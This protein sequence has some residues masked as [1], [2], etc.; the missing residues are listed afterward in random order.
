M[1]VAVLDRHAHGS[2]PSRITR[3]PITVDVRE[4][5]SG[6]GAALARTAEPVTMGLPFPRGLCT[7]PRVISVVSGGPERAA[8]HIDE[9]SAVQVRVLD[10]WPDGSIR[11]AL[12]DFQ[13]D[14]TGR[15]PNRYDV[16]IHDTPSEPVKGPRIAI[17]RQDQGLT[18]DTGAARFVLAPDA[19]FPFA[20]VT[21]NE[22][23]VVDPAR[24]GLLVEGA[25]GESRRP[26]FERIE[27]E[28]EG[29]LRST[30]RCDGTVR[31]GKDAAPLQLTARVHF[32]AGSATVRVALTI[33]N[34][35][36]AGHPGGCWTLGGRGSVLLRDVSLRLALAGATTGASVRCSTEPGAAYADRDAPFELYQDSSGGDNWRSTNHQNREGTVTLRFRGYRVREST[37][38][39]SGD[40]AT[41][42]VTQSRGGAEI[43]VAMPQFW[44]N[45][46]KAIEADD[47]GLTL[48]LFPRQSADL[49][50][51]QG[52]EQKT[53]T[54]Y[55]AFDRDRV[56]S[57]PGMPGVPLDW[58]RSP[59]LARADPS[60]YC[61]SGAVS[62]LVPIASDP[63]PDY[64]ALAQTG[65]DG[66]DT[67]ARKTE[68]IDEYGWRNFGDLYA[69]HEAV[70]KADGPP[71]VSHYNNQYDGIAGFATRFLRSADAR[72][73]TL[74]DDL[75]SHVADIDEYHTAGDKAAY[76]HGLFWHTYHYVD[77]A[78]SAHRSYPT[79]P[80]V[81]GG[82]SAEHNY[83]AGL[84]LHYY[85]TG[86]PISRETAVELAQWVV[87]MEDGRLTVFRWLDRGATGLATMTGSPLY[88][89]PGRGGANSIGA[90]ITGHRA[91]G[92]ARFLATAE[93]LIRRCVHPD[94][95]V[96]A[97]DLLNAEQRWFYTV[98]LQ[99][100]GKYLDY[101]VELG[102]VDAAYAYAR[103]SLLHYA[104]WMA[105]H[106]YP[107]LDRPEIL[108]YPT[109]TWAAQDMRKS[110]VFTYAAKHTAGETRARFLERADFFFHESVAKLRS[111]PS[112]TLTRPVVLMLTNGLM[113]AGCLRTAT[114]PAPAPEHLAGFGKPESFV[115]QKTRAMKRARLIVAA[116]A[117]MTVIAAA[118]AVYFLI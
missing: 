70:F 19:P 51:I 37:A 98:F 9:R 117:A 86:N 16:V 95:D 101:K 114:M 92:E 53:H 79:H 42:I 32:F 23:A 61:A 76:N 96:A 102:Q 55:L 69:D 112:H 74:M 60:W 107:Y 83:P 59:L 88:H 21:V 36:P 90:L 78:T 110:D 3:I 34:P 87:D 31:A 84:L 56:T 85:L 38:E 2:E 33:R 81:G 10:R 4:S 80:T 104:A 68:K 54:F 72:W 97:R 20:S 15:G 105:D 77:A 73:W 103:A 17:A 40:R 44:Q 39:R 67:F 65:V 29:P 46:P 27:V 35:Q 18:V 45:F 63:D 11:W 43:G 118:A 57:M 24:G 14:T 41:P 5:T 58:C 28:E 1:R 99:A 22:H 13:A 113:H 111:M 82:P 71:V 49:H 66:A 62:Y 47:D 106:E 30:V 25:S 89:G 12:L 52:G 64:V 6:D 93:T 91:T 48:R 75:A 50:E 108:E 26:T 109:E 100:L 115:P 7:D 94:D 116:G 8:P